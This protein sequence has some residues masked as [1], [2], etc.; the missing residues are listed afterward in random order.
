MM[1]MKKKKKKKEEKKE[2]K[3]KK[4]KVKKEKIKENKEQKKVIKEEK[5]IIDENLK[6][7]KLGNADREIIG[8]ITLEDLIESLLKIHFNKESEVVRKS[9]RKSTI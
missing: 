2:D 4:K 3:N 5:I 1:M 6:I 9:I 8:I 7:D